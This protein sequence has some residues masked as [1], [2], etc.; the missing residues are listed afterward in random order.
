MTQKKTR[1]L[2]WFTLFPI[3]VTLFTEFNK[4]TVIWRFR[5]V[6]LVDLV[7]LA[8]FY[9]LVLYA[10][11]NLVKPAGLAAKCAIGCLVLFLYGHAMHV[12]ANS[13]N[14]FI[15]EVRDYREVVPADAYDLIYF[16]DEDLS[17]LLMFISLAALFIIWSYSETPEKE[18]D[19][20]WPITALGFIEG[21][22]LAVAMIEATKLYLTFGLALV[23]S[24]SLFRLDHGSR[25]NTPL[26][27]YALWL[28]FSLFATPIIY[29]LVVGNLDLPSLGRS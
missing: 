26:S 8:P 28:A 2:A 6:D 14:T 12:T 3:V 10:L 18:S 15:T 9:G 13:I 27:R 21:I 24:I 7:I 20:L 22:A 5:I 1:L 23:I 25:K 16:L 17:H 11:H 29:W 19:S 4:S